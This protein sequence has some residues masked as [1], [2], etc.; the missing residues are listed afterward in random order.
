MQETEAFMQL[1]TAWKKRLTDVAQQSKTVD[2][3]EETLKLEIFAGQESP[4]SFKSQRMQVQVQLMQ[5][6]MVSGNSVDL[7]AGFISWLQ[8][9]S[10]NSADLSLIERIKP[11]YC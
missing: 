3:Q 2:R 4:G 7:Q 1:S 6:Q 11:I 5:E 10:I 8:K 9:G